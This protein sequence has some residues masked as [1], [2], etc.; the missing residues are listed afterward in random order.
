[1]SSQRVYTIA[2]LNFMRS[3]IVA[4][5]PTDFSDGLDQQSFQRRVK[6]Q[7]PE[8]LYNGKSRFIGET[9][10]EAATP[11]FFKYALTHY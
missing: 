6:R 8:P 10:E 9:F 3:Q 11:G 4:L 5:L 2:S 7:F 1:M